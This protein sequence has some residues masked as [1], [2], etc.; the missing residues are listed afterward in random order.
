MHS[1]AFKLR[2][3]PYPDDR[4]AESHCVADSIPAARSSSFPSRHPR[5]TGSRRRERMQDTAPSIGD[6]WEA[7]STPS[8]RRPGCPGFLKDSGCQRPAISTDRHCPDFLRMHGGARSGRRCFAL[9]PRLACEEGQNR[10]QGGQS[11][12]GRPLEQ[13]QSLRMTSVPGQ[14]IAVIR[15]PHVEGGQET[16]PEGY[17][18]P[19]MVGRTILRN[20]SPW[21]RLARHLSLGFGKHLVELALNNAESGTQIASLTALVTMVMEVGRAVAWP[22]SI[23]DIRERPGARGISREKSRNSRIRNGIVEQGTVGWVE[24]QARPTKMPRLAR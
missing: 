2:Q 13:Q 22:F 3:V 17:Q 4:V 21:R 18:D 9:Q 6:D 7:R 11:A 20:G 8:Y 1:S 23:S 12:H 15:G 5:L 16:S 19:E 10:S 14:P 24:P